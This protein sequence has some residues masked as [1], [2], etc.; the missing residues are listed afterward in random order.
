LALDGE[1]SAG[2]IF[3]VS[4][5]IGRALAPVEQLLGLW[6]QVVHVRSAWGRLDGLL[7]DAEPAA[8]PMALPAPQ[9]Q[10][11]VHQA[12]A[13]APDRSRPI[14][15]NISCAAMPGDVVGVIG[16]SGSGKS[17]LAR[18]LIGIDAPAA[19]QVRLDGAE[20]AR[21]P[22]EALGPFIGY[23]PQSVDLMEGSVAE[24]ISRFGAVDAD[25]VVAAARLAGVHELVLN[26]PQG[27]DTRLGPDGAGLSGGQ[28]Q[29]VA[30]ARAL[31]GEPRLVVL[32]EPNAYLDADGE[33]AL[34][35]ALR[36]LKARGA[37][38]F[39]ITQRNGVLGLCDK[40]LVLQ[41]GQAMAFGARQDVLARL[42]A[43]PQS[44]PAE[45]ADVAR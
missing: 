15:V 38:V 5:I 1:L 21:W 34:H 43:A 28:K 36:S 44:T 8:P 27:Y 2:V 39:V 26:L 13:L 22:R 9:G 12:S 31:Y 25:Q 23:L 7:A 11:T 29:R 19:G 33:V 45:A 16:P 18:L 40:L 3:A 10:L 17:T 24:N 14:L 35:A 41:G 20:L 4:L 32:D 30:L 37:T 42:A 6:R